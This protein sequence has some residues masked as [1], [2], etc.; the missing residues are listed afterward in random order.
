MKMN[1]SNCEKAEMLV[2]VLPYVNR[3]RDK[4]I[5]IKYGGNAMI[6]EESEKSRH[7]GFVIDEIS[8]D[9]PY[10]CPWRRTGHQ[11]YAEKAE[12]R[13]PLRAGAARDR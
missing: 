3:F 10:P 11:R 5:V 12:G 1:K 9:A 7:A 2:E 13:E 4:I 8:G 6:N